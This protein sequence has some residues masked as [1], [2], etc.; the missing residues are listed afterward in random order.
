[1]KV[2]ALRPSYLRS[3]TILATDEMQLAFDRTG[4]RTMDAPAAATEMLA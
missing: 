3:P 4:V 2:V 1:M